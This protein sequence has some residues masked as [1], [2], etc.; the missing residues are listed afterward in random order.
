METP[1]RLPDRLQDLKRR[2]VFQVAAWY[3]VA[4]W[5]VI[6]IATS[7]FPYLGLPPWIVTAVIIAAIVGFPI[8]LLVGTSGGVVIKAVSAVLALA[9][10]AAIALK[11]MNKGETAVTE[12]ALAAATLSQVTFSPE[13]EEFPAFS[14][15]ARKLVF[16]R[17]T[18]GFKQL[19]SRDMSSGEEVQLTHENLDHIQPS[20]SP[21]GRMLL[22]VRA[23]EL[24]GRLEPA[25]VFDMYSGGDVWRMDVATGR[26][27]KIIDNAYNP[28]YSSDAKHIAFEASYVGPRRLWIA[29]EVGRNPRQVT[30]D[31]S[32]AVIH[33][34]PRW[35]PDGRL[36]A[37]Q[38]I[39]KNK[40]DIRVVDVASG[41][42]SNITDDLVRDADPVWL[43]GSRAVIF[44]SPR[45][46]GWNLWRANINASGKVVGELKQLTTGA[47]Q[48]LQAAPAAGGKSIAFVTLNQN[49]DVWLLPVDPGTGAARGEPTPLI[50]TTREDSRAAWSPDGKLVAFNSDRSGDMNLFVYSIADRTTRQLTRGPGGDFQASWAPDGKR[51]VF[52]SSRSGSADI[53]SVDVASGALQQLTR[54]PAL[55][56]NPLFAPD[57]KRVAYQ[58]DRGGRREVWVMN[59]D[60]SNQKQVTNTGVSDHFMLWSKDSNTLLYHRGAGQVMQVSVGS[61]ESKLFKEIKG[62]SHISL[63]PDL[64]SFIDVL[65][66]KTLWVSPVADGAPKELFRFPDADSRIDYPRWSPD[67]KYVLFDRL[68]PTGGDIWMLQLKPNR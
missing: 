10:V 22:F 50:A 16:S 58:S 25:D 43:P 35:S 7:T 33:I 19:F 60:G 42:I 54:D 28:T 56:V 5:V 38:N 24:G 46:G 13:V 14:P 64:S 53:W 21:D 62:G 9:V 67:G 34:L 66:H 1:R 37:F 30:T 40:L 36:L 44:S 23:K 39:E 47:G 45:G 20:W 11:S 41:T 48:D 12:N 68:K 65:E 18:G 2:R 51:I 52:F 26:S 29:D 49:A 61:G 15:D 59:A 3:A 63:S 27:Q 6:Q 57:G 8:A 17:E 31:A 4:A 55:D 32:E